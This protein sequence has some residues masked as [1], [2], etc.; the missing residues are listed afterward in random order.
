[1]FELKTKDLGKYDIA[2]CGAGIAGVSAAVAAARNGSNVILI[3]KAGSLGGTMTEGLMPLILD[4]KNKGGIV[5][6]LY[7]FLD[8]HNMTCPRR[9]PRVDENGNRLKGELLDT[10]GAKY[11]FD[12][13]ATEAG[14]KIMYHSQVAALDMDGDLIKSILIVTECGNYTLSADIFIDA[15]GNG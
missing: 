15:T 5:R 14:V 1:M 9:G 10:E 11:Y 13:I 2:V 8:E 6:D 7:R 3:E 4:A 12:K